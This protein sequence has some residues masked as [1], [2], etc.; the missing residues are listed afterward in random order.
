MSCRYLSV[1]WANMKISYDKEVDMLYL[2]LSPEPSVESA[3][4]APNVVADYAED[5]TIVGYEIAHASRGVEA[6]IALP[7]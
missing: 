3:E 7:A 4:I 5:G 6:P 2:Q 1:D